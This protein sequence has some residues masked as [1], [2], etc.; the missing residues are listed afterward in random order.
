[1][2]RRLNV[3]PTRMVMNDLKKRL[4]VARQGHKL[5]KEKQDSLIRQ[6]MEYYDHAQN[7]R[8]QIETDFDLMNLD[9]QYASLEMDE[10]VIR[11]NLQE[12][13]VPMVVESKNHNVFGMSVPKYEIVSETKVSSSAS[14]FRSH[15]RIDKMKTSHPSVR[16]RLV[17]LAELEKTCFILGNEIRATRRRVNALEHRTIPQ[18][19]VTIDYI[20]LRIDDQARSQQSRVMKVTN[21][22]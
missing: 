22:A 1:M 10:S 13:D 17:E 19:E 15:Y 16:Q 20:R 8:R 6:F 14:L 21:K 3:N 18:F 12:S 5:L 11:D 2:T 7:M 4:E 9:Y